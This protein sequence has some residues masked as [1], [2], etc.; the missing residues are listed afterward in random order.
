MTIVCRRLVVMALLAAI[1]LLGQLGTG[2]AAADDPA[3]HKVNSVSS[4]Y[5]IVEDDLGT[6]V[7]MPDGRTIFRYMIRKPADSKLTANSVCCLFP[8]NTPSGERAVDF[9]PPDH[10]HHRGVFLTWHAIGGKIPAD[11]WGWG[12]W[13]PT[14]GRVIENRSVKPLEPDAAG[15]ELAVRNQWVAEGEVLVEENTTIAA[16]EVDGVYVVDLDFKLVPQA[17]L[18]LRQ[19]AFGGLCVKGRKGQAS[20]YTSPGG[21]VRIDAPH[22]LKPETDWPS[23]D[24]YDYTCLLENGKAVGVTVFDHP[25]NPPSLWHNLQAIAMVNPCIVAKGPVKLKTKEPL[26][27]RYRLVVHDGEPPTALL[28]RLSRQW[29]GR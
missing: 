29:R 12:E 11:F 28:E 16:R 8:L 17:D 9:A 25:G 10:P 7:K 2:S 18:T 6:V 4:P 19:T 24:W 13:A 27:L 20:K 5:S 14:Q 23:A 21:E 1:V 26:R 3:P 15:A 22:Y